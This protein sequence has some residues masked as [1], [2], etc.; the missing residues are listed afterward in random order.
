MRANQTRLGRRWRSLE[1]VVLLLTSVCPTLAQDAARAQLA[2]ALT[3]IVPT[4]QWRLVSEANRGGSRL[5]GARL[6]LDF[7]KGARSVGIGF[8][9]RSLP[10]VIDRIRLQ[11]RGDAKGPV[12]HLFLR[13][14]FMTFHKRLDPLAGGEQELVTDGPPGPGWEWF[15]GEN[16]G[17][18][19]GPLRPGEL[20]FEADGAS[21][22]G[23][24]EILRIECEAHC[25]AERRVLM[26]ARTEDP[27]GA[28]RFDC[29]L[30]AF[31]DR[32]ID[33]ALRWTVK[34]WDGA[35]LE[36]S[37]QSVVLRPNL[38]SQTV[39]V[40]C[41]P[42]PAGCRFA[43]AE[44]AFEAPDQKVTPV[45]AYWLAPLEG[46]PDFTLRPGS[47]FGMGVYLGRYGDAEMEKVARLA[48]EAGVKWSRED[49]SWQRLEPR[50]GEFHWDYYDRLL[51]RAHRYGI[52][53]YAIVGYWTGWTKPYT[54][55]GIEDYVRFVRA[56]VAHYRDRIH[57]WEIWNEPNIF[58]WQGP[59]ELYAELLTKSYGAIK[60]V[61]PQAQVLGLSTSGINF[62]FIDQMLAKQAPF[63]VLT[64]HP[65][66]TVLKE[67]EFIGDLKRASDRVQLA[68]GTRRPVWITGDGLG[69]AR[70]PPRPPA[71]LPARHSARPGRASSRAPT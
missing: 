66:R 55:E 15:A 9:D 43:E 53:V 11:V 34:T 52:S 40:P 13:T 31:S 6:T 20:R 4:N 3:A 1:L 68:A 35:V 69:H 60:E 61:D 58:F 56:L 54:A 24:L 45:Q 70:A 47:P 59:K 50:R 62:K 39:S 57:Q 22:K 51:A 42:L 7:S 8:P 16:D 38:E 17:K 48:G 10:G 64:V 46:E 28:I 49:Y 44:F 65:Y 25:P 30:R 32:A 23:T 33:G 29:D 63:D 27:A 2:Y 36:H 26:T 37:R 21:A 18:I 5:E 19:H 67:D 12:V 41:P 71:G 14:H